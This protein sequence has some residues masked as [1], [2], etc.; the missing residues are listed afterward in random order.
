VHGVH[1]D[2]FASCMR[3]AVPVPGGWA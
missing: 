3:R 1:D 2:E